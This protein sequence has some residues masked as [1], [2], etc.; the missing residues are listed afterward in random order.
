MKLN[1]TF[2]K[3]PFCRF[4]DEQDINQIELL[5]PEKKFCYS[6][7]RMTLFKW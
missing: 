7:E 5:N 1:F 6:D 3:F 4:D 2:E